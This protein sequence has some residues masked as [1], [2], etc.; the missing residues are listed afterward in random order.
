MLDRPPA[1]RNEIERQA[2]S[3]LA[4]AADGILFLVDASGTCGYPLDAQLELRAAIAEEFSDVPVVTVW[5]KA[6]LEPPEASDR[7]ADVGAE[8]AMSITEAEGVDA[9]LD[10]M[11]EAIGYEPQLPFEES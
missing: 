2:A 11:V 3:A 1:E 9:A 5:N 10:A 4:H 6:D 8:V 7:A